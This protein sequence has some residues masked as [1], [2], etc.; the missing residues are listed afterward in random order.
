MKIIDA[1]IH[2]IDNPNCSLD[3][4]MKYVKGPDFPTGGIV[5][6]LSGIKQAYETGKGKI[7]I[8]S[9]YTLEEEKGKT[10]IIITEIPFESNKA[11][12]VKK[13]DDIRIDK[14]IDGIAEVRDES[15]ADVRVVI[16]LKKGANKDLILNYL[17]KN[18]DM[19]ISYNF[20]MVSIVN[21]RPKLLGLCGALDAFIAHQKEVV[22]RRT[23]FDLTSC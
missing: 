18:T 6:G 13:M 17:L 21:K 3:T 4:L 11:N 1:T 7:V 14:K 2:R 15:A 5:E 10:S 22:T 20:N 8:R 16:E 9:R 23:E 12:M 19:Q